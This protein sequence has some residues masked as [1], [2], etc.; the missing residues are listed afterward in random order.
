MESGKENIGLNPEYK[1]GT[2]EN[3]KVLTKQIEIRTNSQSNLTMGDVL[4]RFSSFY[5]DH[6][7]ELRVIKTMD[8]KL[9]KIYLKHVTF[10]CMW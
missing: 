3:E 1:K 4:L 8:N 5:N 6:K 7:I 9:N 10:Q 2:C